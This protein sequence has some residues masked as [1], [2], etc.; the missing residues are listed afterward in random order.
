M[1]I[2][3][4]KQMKVA[5]IIDNN[6]ASPHGN[7]KGLSYGELAVLL[8]TYIVSEADHRICCLERWV[9]EHQ[10][11]LEGITGWEIQEK[12]GTDDRCGDLLRTLGITESIDQIEISLSKHLVKAYKLPTQ[13]ARSD[14]T[15]FSVY[16]HITEDGEE[17]SLIK[18]GYSKDKRPNLR[19]YRQMLATL[20]PLGMPLL[21][22]TLAGNG[23]DESE[24]LPTWR[25]MTEII[26][27]KEFLYLADS[28]A[29]TWSN[30]A[31]IHREGG[32]YCFPL[33]MTQPR[34]KLL[35]DWVKNPPT[36]V[37]KIIEQDER[38]SEP[39]LMG[40]GFEVPLGNIWVEPETEKIYQ[41][42]ERWLVIKSNALASR[43]I[44]GLD[45]RLAKGEKALFSLEKRPGKDEKLLEQK[46]Q[47]I[48]KSYRLTKYIEYS[49]EKKISYKKVY[50]GCGSRSED[51]SYRRVRQTNLILNYQRLSTEIES[52]KIVAGWRLYVTNATSERLSLTEAVQAYKQQWQPE[53]GFHRFKKGR[54]SALPIYFRDEE[55]IKGL[56]FLLTIALRVFTL[57]EFVVRRQLHQCKSSLARLYEGNPKRATNRPTAEKMLR[58]FNNITLYIHKDDSIEISGLNLLQQ[59]ILRLMNVEECIYT[60]DYFASG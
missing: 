48:L 10:R 13:R 23:G 53:M 54:L 31:L 29:S 2:Y 30:R 35:A 41:W 25:K 22:A 46:I 32:I 58:A 28:K 33:A 12:E 47:E 51:S 49:I 24:Y 3:W 15:S 45:S 7:R 43:Q 17:E 42:Q 44:K 5:S 19:Q 59:Q 37:I 16:H 50:K 34:P 36:E 52:F 11:S 4:L 55:K 27:H 60:T 1:I 8:L 56:M 14:T 18:F 38:E 26:G 21:G 6:L 57:M 40:N 20:D 39:S 9:K